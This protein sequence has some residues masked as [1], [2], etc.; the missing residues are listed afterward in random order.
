MVAGFGCTTTMLSLHLIDGQLILSFGE[1]SKEMAMT[2]QE[3]GRSVRPMIE[4]ALVIVSDVLK[5]IS[6]VKKVRCFYDS[7][8]CSGTAGGCSYGVA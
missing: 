7:V 5:T 1:R 4:F 3:T 6:R 2:G 8:T